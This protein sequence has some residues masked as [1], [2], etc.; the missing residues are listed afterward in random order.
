ERLLR[1]QKAPGSNPGESTVPMKHEIR[2]LAP[3]AGVF[4]IVVVSTATVSLVRSEF[5]TMAIGRTFMS[6]FF[7]TFG[8]FKLY[9][10]EGFREAFREY[11]VLAERSDTYAS[12]YPFLEVGLG[13]LYAYLLVND[14]VPLQILTHSAAILMMSINAAGVLNELRKGNELQCACL[15][16][17]FNVPMTKVTLV[18]DLLMASMAAWMLISVL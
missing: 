4:A 5:G 14:P 18:E 17:V 9:N 8:G 11:D 6:A 1:K 7:L 3:L 13:L 2:D 12:V 10:L 16:N 15:G